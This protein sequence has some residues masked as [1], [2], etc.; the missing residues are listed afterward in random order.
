[1]GSDLFYDQVEQ[2]AATLNQDA[3]NPVLTLHFGGLDMSGCDFHPSTKD[4]HTLAA[5]LQTLLDQHP[6]YWNRAN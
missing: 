5:S 6:D 3:R 2:I 1:M 4:D